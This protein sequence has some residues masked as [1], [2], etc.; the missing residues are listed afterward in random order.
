MKQAGMEKVN[1]REVILF[2][3]LATAI[4]APFRLHWIAPEKALTLPGGLN[5]LFRILGGIGPFV[6]YLIMYHLVKSNVPRTNNFYGRSKTSSIIS[7][8]LIPIGL[9]I[10]GVSNEAGLNRNYFGLL[11]GLTLAIYSLGEEYGWRGY[12]QQALQPLPGVLKIFTIAVLW[13]V[14]HL[15]FLSQ[16]ISAK[17]H[18]IHFLFLVAGSWGLL[19]IT[20]ISRSILFAGAVHQSFNILTDVKGDFLERLI[21]LF[22]AVIVWIILLRRMSANTSP[23]NAS[24]SDMDKS[25]R[26]I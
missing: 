4:S 10:V 14:W 12:L 21:V 6:A 3:V 1:W 19:K 22:A 23:T 13:Y 18:V 24:S 17:N 5:V 20:D 2:F 25:D 11:Y 8:A 26:T 7:I 9:S 16:E 15:N